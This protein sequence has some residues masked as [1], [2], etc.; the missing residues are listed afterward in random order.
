MS[1]D[2]LLKWDKTQS[3]D[4]QEMVKYG[5]ESIAE[6][7][8]GH[9]LHNGFVTTM[10]L[11]QEHV[12]IWSDCL[13]ENLPFLPTLQ[14]IYFCCRNNNFC[15]G[16]SEIWY[17]GKARNFR[18]RWKNHHKLNALKALKFVSLYLL[19][20]PDITNYELCRIEREYINLF[21]PVF[22]DTSSPERNL[23]VAP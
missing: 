16:K 11:N 10:H 9:F 18:E 20:L 7:L 21:Q 5:H 4:Y 2:T 22:N 17:I 8:D 14:G 3:E 15:S 12:Q 6:Q 23:R 19:P 1:L 13:D